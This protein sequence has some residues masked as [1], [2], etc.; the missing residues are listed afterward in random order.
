MGRQ[1]SKDVSRRTFF[2]AAAAGAAVGATLTSA[3][4]SAAASAGGLTSRQ[5]RD[6]DD[7]LLRQQAESEAI[8]DLSRACFVAMDQLDLDGWFSFFSDDVFGQDGILGDMTDLFGLPGPLPNCSLHPISLYR[9]FSQRMF[10]KVGIPGRFMKYVHATGS[11]QFGGAVDLHVMPNTFFQNGV[12]IVSYLTIRGGKI[13]RRND[14]YDTAELFPQDIA[15]IHKNGVPRFS[16]LAGPSPGDVANA[17]PDYLSYVRAFHHALSEGDVTRVM[18]F[19]DDD[20]LLV[21]PLLFRGSGM[22]GP[23]NRGIQVRG[24]KAIARFFQKVLSV[25]PDGRNSSLVHVA[26]GLAG[27]GYEWLGGGIYAQEGIARTGINGVTSLELHMR[28]IA[29]ISVKFDTIQMSAEQ[30]DTVRGALAGECLVPS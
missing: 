17:S 19:F 28:K 30:R 20:A 22:Y 25:L 14:Y 16:C 24:V 4:T 21:H 3:L 15:F 1:I 6:C 10:A 12:D 18:Q 5:E 2:K 29:R 7:L 13:V 11:V 9:A 8:G 23:Y 27:G 26:G